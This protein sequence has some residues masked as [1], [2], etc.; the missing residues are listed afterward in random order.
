MIRK[1]CSGGM[2]SNFGRPSGA[3]LVGHFP[4]H[5]GSQRTLPNSP[6]GHSLYCPKL[7]TLYYVTFYEM[8]QAAMKSACSTC[9]VPQN[10]KFCFGT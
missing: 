7:V 10:M 6:L 5:V 8:K 4:V 1:Q 3:V 2:I 9:T